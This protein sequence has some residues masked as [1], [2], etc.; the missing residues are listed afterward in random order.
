MSA[1]TARHLRDFD[2]ISLAEVISRA[3][4]LT[5]VDRKYVIGV[6]ESRALVAAMP[7]GTRVLEIDGLREFTYS[8]V[9]LD[10]DEFTSFLIS[11]RSRR[12][13][14][15]VRTRSYLDTGGTWLEVKI[16]AARG[17]TVK[18]RIEHPDALRAR[19]LTDAGRGFV[20]GYI[21]EAVADGLH[22]VLTTGY[23]RSTFLL[24]GSAGRFTLDVDLSWS[25]PDTTGRLERPALAIIETKTG[26]T[27]SAVDRMLW[28][29]GHRPVRI[30]K[31][32]VGMAA[33]NPDLPHLKWHRSVH[34]HLGTHH[35][36]TADHTLRSPR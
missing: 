10:T 21:G 1:S 27:P 14:W 12:G 26:S 28:S 13:R 31:Y 15:K 9:Y 7:R 30:S 5:R 23:R 35:P 22:P 17:R 19:G 18:H 8:S 6:E 20:G 25:S 29:H 11:G 3:E 16:R 2:P 4:L 36:R 32:G 33:L 34:T 24:D